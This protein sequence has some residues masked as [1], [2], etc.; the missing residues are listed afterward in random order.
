[1]SSWYTSNLEKSRMM[2][3]VWPTGR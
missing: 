1:M 3:P 2:S